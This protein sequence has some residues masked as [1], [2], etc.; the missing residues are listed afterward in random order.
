MFGVTDGEKGKTPS[1]RFAATSPE[2]PGEAMGEDLRETSLPT[3]HAAGIAACRRGGTR[4]KWCIARMLRTKG[5][6][7]GGGTVLAFD[8]EAVALWPPS[9]FE[10]KEG[11][12]HGERE[13]A[14]STFVFEIPF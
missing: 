4:G 2:G 12:R 9:L 1:V 5:V 10:S 8:S 11:T 3:W 7:R 6:M 13:T 14:G